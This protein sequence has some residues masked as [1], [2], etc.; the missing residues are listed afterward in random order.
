[1][2]HSSFLHPDSTTTSIKICGLMD[3]DTVDIAVGSGANA[4]G[5]V[6]VKSSPRYIERHQ[7]NRLVLQL[8]D[9]VLGVAVLQ[10]E[11]NLDHYA[12]WNGWLQLCGEESHETVANAPC[13]VIKAMQWNRDDVLDW[14][15]CEN[16]E[17]ILVDG[18]TG[19]LGK[20]FD[21]TELAKLIPSLLTPIIIAGG[22]SPENVQA[23]IT[24]ANPAGVDVSS[25]VESTL[26]VKDPELICNFIEQA[27][28]A[29]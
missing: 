16:L 28:S 1:M 9:D 24:Q 6:Q 7:A 27:Q 5:F 23:V 2:K 4:I 19:G 22:L 29:S 21:V 14:D 10:D 26:G 25:G 13:P 3:E 20:T 11:Q 12:N 18:S 15:G 17:A 8:P